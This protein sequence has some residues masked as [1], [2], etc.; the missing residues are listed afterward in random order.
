ML[1]QIRVASFNRIN[2]GQTKLDLAMIG[3][4]MLLQFR[5][6]NSIGTIPRVDLKFGVE[7]DKN[8]KNE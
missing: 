3:K 4:K 5:W 7:I 6:Y 2:D 1:T 8:L